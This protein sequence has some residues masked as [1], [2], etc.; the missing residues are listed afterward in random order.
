MAELRRRTA[1]WLFRVAVALILI[2]AWLGVTGAAGGGPRDLGALPAFSLLALDG[3]K[4]ERASLEGQVTVV[5]FWASW[6]PPCRS[7]APILAAVAAD[8]ADE[9]VQFL[10]VLHQDRRE[11]ALE[12]A[13]QYGLHFPTVVD[14]GALARSLGVRSIP[15]TFVVGVDGTILARHFGP[16]SEARLRVLIADAQVIAATRPT[17]VP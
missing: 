5:N 9:G 6:C 14:D 2:L 1:R 13:E 10:G 4:V 16:I 11:P 15:V 12:F 17:A 7:E 3:S 8:T